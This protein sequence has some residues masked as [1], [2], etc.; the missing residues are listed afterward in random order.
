M[1]PGRAIELVGPAGSGKTTLVRALE[2]AFGGITVGAPCGGRDHVRLGLRHA[3]RLL[4]AW[5]RSRDRWLD[6]KELRS[7]NY[8]V[9]WAEALERAPRARLTVF[10]HGPIF[11]LA[12][13][14]AFG[15]RLV[16]SP[17]FVAWAAEAVQRWARLLDAVVWL[18][19]PDAVLAARIDGRDEAH[20]MKGEAAPDTVHFLAR[21]RTTY[22]AL[23]AE[24]R[25]AG[26]PEPIRVDT[27]QEAPEAIAERLVAQLGLVK[28]FAARS[29]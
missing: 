7:L 8:V 15:P 6:E 16:E 4:P 11:R 25:A 21:Y 27:S 17:A 28:E 12:R 20:R 23:L 2:G 10:D 29:A 26:G 9:G 1:Q 5:L 13:L 14:R 3:A 24:L 22:E 19:A 18:D